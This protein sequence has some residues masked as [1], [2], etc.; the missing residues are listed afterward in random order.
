V[1]STCYNVIM[2]KKVV[3]FCLNQIVADKKISVRNLSK[4]AHVGT[5]T[6]DRIMNNRTRAVSLDVL[7]KLCNTLGVE[8]GD[9]LVQVEERENHE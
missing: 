3:I 7:T 4:L 2:N 9:I 6:I 1:V 5:A 8:P